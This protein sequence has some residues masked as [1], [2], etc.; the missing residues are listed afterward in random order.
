MEN[1]KIKQYNPMCYKFN[2]FK[3]SLNL[4]NFIPQ[5]N[6]HF[7]SIFYPS[8]TPISPTIH[9]THLSLFLIYT[10]TSFRPIHLTN[11][12]EVIVID[13][14]GDRSLIVYISIRINRWIIKNRVGVCNSYI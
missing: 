11:T 6:P 8:S 5:F 10:P 2:V 4:L 14:S 1:K 13:F 7:L 12:P 3:N 9:S